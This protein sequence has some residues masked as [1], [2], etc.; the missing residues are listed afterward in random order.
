MVD[1]HS[2]DKVQIHFWTTPKHSDKLNRLSQELGV[3]KTEL[4]DYLISSAD[5]FKLK[6]V[7]SLRK[8]D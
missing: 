8:R 4:I 3:T 7:F 1:R 5:I 2:K 6:P